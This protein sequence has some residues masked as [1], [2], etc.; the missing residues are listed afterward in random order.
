MDGWLNMYIC[1]IILLPATNI[2]V[3]TIFI[4]SFPEI[5]GNSLTKV[6]ARRVQ[7]IIFH[8]DLTFLP[9]TEYITQNV[10]L[11]TTG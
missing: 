4:Q 10:K 6:K 3:E 7:G 2:L 5:S 11:L 9:H 8:E 1:R